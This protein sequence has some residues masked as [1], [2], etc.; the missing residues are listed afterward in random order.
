MAEKCT[1]ITLPVCVRGLVS[2]LA[3]ALALLL[4][5][6]AFAQGYPSRPIRLVVPFPAGG[7]TDVVAR[8]VAQRLGDALKTSVVID[9]KPGAGSILGTDF[10]AKAAPDGYTL[11]VAA[12]P[13]IAPGPL[14]RSGMP[15]DPLKDFV[16]I[17]LLGTFPNGFVVRADYPA[18]TMAEF[19]AMARTKPGAINYAS[20]GVGSSGFLSGE[21]LKQIA[22]INMVHVPYKGSAPAITDMIGG[23]IDGMFES[24]VTATSYIKGGKLRLLAVTSEKRMKKFPDVPTT[25]ELVPGVSGG[26]WFGISAPAKTPADIVQR[27]EVELKAVMNA[28]DVQARLSDLGMTPLPLTG[29]DYVSFIQN[30]NQKWAPV[31]KAGGIRVD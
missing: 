8:L 3:V 23:Q 20:A 30:E 1:L 6:L 22:G 5:P 12:N 21:M 29:A 14:M 11:V 7:S 26:A 25:G 18:R 13:A 10:V 9:N 27:L 16:H 31:I 4:P 28:T 17:A 24:L 19:I 2:S 15:Y